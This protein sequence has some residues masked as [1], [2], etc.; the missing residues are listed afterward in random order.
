MVFRPLLMPM[1]DAAPSDWPSDILLRPF[2]A[3]NADLVRTVAPKGWLAPVAKDRYHLVVV[4]AGTAGLVT[5]AIA[6]GLGARVAL[7][8]RHLFGG[9][10]LNF[11]CVP[12]KAVI[13]AARAWHDARRAA[14][15]FG[16]PSVTADGDFG[17]VMARLRRLRADISPVDGVERFR[18]LGIDVFRGHAAFSSSDT[19]RVGEATLRFRRAVIAT[20][21][22]AALP[23]IPGLA[24]TPYDTH[25]SIFSLTERPPQLIVIGGGPIG[26]ELA[27]SFARF[28]SDVTIVHSDGHILP[29]EDTDAAAIVAEALTSDG[30]RLVNGARIERVS[31]D[32]AAFHL[33]LVGDHGRPVLHAD[34]LLVAAG[35]T[36]NVEGLG[37]EAA[38]IGYTRTGVTVN[39]RLRTTNPRVYAIGDV[40]SR[41]QF[42]HLADAQARLVVANALFFGLGGGRASA[43]VVPRVTYTDP[44]VAHVG[45]TA[46]EAAA[47]GQPIETI[48]VRLE[49]NDRARLDGEAEGFL[50]VHV[51]A[52]SDRILGATLVAS[53][54]GEM[55]GEMTLAIT[56]GEGLGAVGKTIHAYPTQAEV[57]R[58]AADAWRRRRFTPRA[59]RLVGW[60]FRAWR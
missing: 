2:D 18:S 49:D 52:G 46:E 3:A 54:A 27:Q 31:F 13:R 55:I 7:V 32:G 25:E 24:D 60:W 6:S 26:S 37:L 4:G 33:H 53:H 16:G 11:G 40:S 10:C 43:L 34:R 1:H 38:G 17:A 12:S 30:V 56:V 15:E 21:A 9:D 59:K 5:A 44:E 22:R 57:F 8:E 36:P 29:R 39:D 41:L 45:L 19:I 23:P 14:A 58:R 28:G 50:K 51:A 42:T 48:T 47:A 20:G 35:R